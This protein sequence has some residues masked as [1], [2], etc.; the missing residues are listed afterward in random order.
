MT[1]NLKLDADTIIDITRKSLEE[2]II[3]KIEDVKNNDNDEE[4]QTLMFLLGALH[5]YSIKEQYQSFCANHQINDIVNDLKKEVESAEKKSINVTTEDNE[6]GS[7]TVNLD[8]D[9]EMV[10]RLASGGLEYSIIKG[11]LN[12]QSASDILEWAERG[13]KEFE[14]DAALGGFVG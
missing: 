2:S 12:T 8:A 10:H 14:T 7:I 5:Y 13:K 11:I 4:L 1:Y 6:D 9:D 3:Y